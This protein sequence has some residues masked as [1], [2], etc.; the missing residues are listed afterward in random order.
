LFEE[1]RDSRLS[2]SKAG[3]GGNG[4]VVVADVNWREVSGDIY[5]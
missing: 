5:T 2:G 3:V 4:E 1:R